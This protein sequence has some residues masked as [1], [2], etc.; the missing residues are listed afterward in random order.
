MALLIVV[1]RRMAER[2]YL[3]FSSARDNGCSIEVG[4]DAKCASGPA[5]AVRAMAYSVRCGES[6]DGDGCLTAGTSGCSWHDCGHVMGR[7]FD[8]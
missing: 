8:A 1:L 6:A 7:I 5:L 4:R 2:I 3:R